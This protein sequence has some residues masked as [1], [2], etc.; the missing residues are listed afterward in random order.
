MTITVTT[1]NADETKAL[2][3]RLA[4]LLTAGD[5]VVLAGRLGSGKTLFVS[6]VAEGLGIN[7]R[8]TSPSFVIA[9]TYNDGFLPLVHV[10]VYRL[11]SLGEF[12]DLDIVD[13]GAQGAVIIEWGEAI[14]AALPPDRLT[15]T[16]EIDGDGRSIAFEP[17]GTW[18]DR[19][20]G[21]LA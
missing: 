1:T 17:K 8:V 15:V 12:D 5:I 18:R 3:R 6:G 9:R 7:E 13:D 20:L 10:D 21:V 16:L 4:P 11:G 2:G 19:D 14:A